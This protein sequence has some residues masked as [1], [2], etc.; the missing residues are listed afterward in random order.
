MQFDQLKRRDFNTMLGAVVP[1]WLMLWPR[2]ALSQH[3]DRM[4]RVGVLMGFTADNADGQAQL[5]AF[6]QSLLQLGWTDG[7]NVRIDTRWGGGEAELQRRYAAELVALAPDVIL[8]NGSVAVGPLLQATRTVPIVFTAITDP[9]GAG[10]V[11]S[12]ARPGGN[13]T[14]FTSFEYGNSGKWLELLKEI[15]PSVTRVAVLRDS[16]IAAGIGQFGAIQSAAPSLGVEVSP[17]NVHDAGEMERAFAA[18]ARSPNGGLIVTSSSLAF[19]HHEL[20]IMLAA[21][22]KLPAVYNNRF[23]VTSGGLVSYGPDRIDQFRRAAGYVDHILKGEKPADLPVQAPTKY[24]LVINLKAAKALGLS[25]PPSLLA[26]AD[27]VIE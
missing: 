18:F 1:V 17:V 14:G 25:I 22:H 20:I 3:A 9:V 16:A 23:F 6:L 24:E 19:I 5:A 21:R 7:G 26:R 15:A 27:E 13:A 10:L 8:G 12:L 4:R 11:D 2:N